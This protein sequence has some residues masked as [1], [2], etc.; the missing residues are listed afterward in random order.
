MEIEDTTT[1]QGVSVH[2]RLVN[3]LSDDKSPSKE[4]G[5]PT[6]EDA[7]STDDIVDEDATVGT[8]T[9]VTDGD[10]DET[11]EDDG[12]SRWM[13]ESLDELAEALEVEPDELFKNVKARIK[14][15]G[16][17]GEA[18]LADLLKSY[19]YEQHLNRRSQQM[20][21]ERK[22]WEEQNA[23]WREDK[24]EQEANLRN[25]FTALEQMIAADYQQTNWK[26]LQEEDP[27]A[28]LIAQQNLQ[29]R[30]AHLEQMKQAIQEQSQKEADEAKAKQEDALRQLML[31]EREM[32]LEA[33]PE[34]Q[35]PDVRN[36]DLGE[37]GAYLGKTVGLTPEHYAQIAD[38]RLFVVARKAMMYDQM[39][40][41]ADPKKRELKNKPKFV[42][43]G[44]RKSDSDAK[45]KKVA[46]LRKRSRQ[47]DKTATRELLKMKISR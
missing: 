20:A 35:N 45:A 14:V 2:D 40:S 18:T 43:P 7:D 36:K 30:F 15:D 10:G 34:W 11:T 27:T 44:A 31:R 13:P 22:E 5:Q 1:Q 17:S 42:P 46:Q 47:G 41:K 3:F 24:A 21:G 37:I 29:Q 9:E 16:E 32:A 23:K 39:Q 33:I 4:D 8:D 12:D 28:Y 6:V 25:T 38:H 26:E 19:Q